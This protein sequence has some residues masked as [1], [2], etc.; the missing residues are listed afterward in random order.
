MEVNCAGCAGC[1]LDWRP[2]VDGLE[3]DHERRGPHNPLDDVYNLVPLEREE[4][5]GFLEAGLGDALVPRLWHTEEGEERFS[6]VEIDGHRLAAIEGRPVFFVGLRKTPKPVA[7]FDRDDGAWL[8]TCIFLDP[9]TLQCR[10]HGDE[11]YPAECDEYPS[12]NLALEVET[13]CERVENRFGDRRLLDDEPDDVGGLLLGP[14]AIGAKLFAYPDPDDLRGIVGRLA[15]GQSTDADR[16]AFV[17]VAAASSPGTFAI[18]D[19]HREWA[20][21]RTLEADSWVG[22]SIEEWER[23]AAGGD[24]DDR[25][26]DVPDPA[27][28]RETVPDPAIA[29]EVERAR[30]APETPGWDAIE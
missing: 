26:P 8:P 21:E 16:A 15:D 7:P 14:G 1:C 18:S 28:A 13:E 23:R 24:S 10:I 20:F 12:H 3:C 6:T 17:A 22:R 19:H 4:V 29:R 5:R 27:V 2:L 11:L 25:I 30:G 9:E